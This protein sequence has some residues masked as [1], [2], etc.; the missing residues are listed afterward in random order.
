MK[1]TEVSEHVGAEVSDV[2]L[3]ELTDADVA[4]LN[5]AWAS[6][7]VLFVRDQQLTPE[8][9]IAF[10]KR[11]A[12][13]E[14]NRFFKKVDDYPQIAHVLKEPDDERNVGGGWHTDHS[15]DQV[16][17]RGSIM[18]ARELPPAGGATRFLSVGAAY[19]Q[20]SEGLR[21]TLE[22]LMVQHSNRHVFGADSA[23][24]MQMGGRLGNPEGVGD[25]W[26]P[27]VVKHPL[28][29]R[30]LLY[31]NPAFVRHFRGWTRDESLPLLQY[32]YEQTKR[33]EFTYD[34]DWQP[35]SVAMWDNRSTWHWALNDYPGHRR[36][37]HRIT[38]KGDEL[39]AANP[40]LASLAPV[41]AVGD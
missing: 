17:A 14:V 35:G 39:E 32:L 12:P 3:R 28:S 38:V 20:L 31:V 23:R 37:M 21:E 11:F 26:H 6:Y 13:I 2:D 15:Y 4:S 22:G 7:G 41:D 25:A 30:R 24:R 40:A 8:D 29:G 18:V 16:P 10:A 34:F 33:D 19:D 5:Q 9:H 27:A 1:I 36:S